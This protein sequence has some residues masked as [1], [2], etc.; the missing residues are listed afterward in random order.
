MRMQKSESAGGGNAVLVV[1]QSLRDVAL[2]DVGSEHGGDG[3]QVL[4]IFSNLSEP[5]IP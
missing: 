5:K 3:L 4:E 1:F 2:R